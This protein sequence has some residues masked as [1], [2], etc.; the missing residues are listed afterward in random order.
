MNE[1]ISRGPQQAV[2][3]D[4]PPG[5]RDNRGRGRREVPIDDLGGN[6]ETALLLKIPDSRVGPETAFLQGER[7]RILSAAMANLTPRIRRA[8]ELRELGELSTK[9]TARTT[10]V[11]VAAVKARVFHGRKKLRRVLKRVH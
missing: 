1:R 5:V 8:I 11:S 7:R 10:G 2:R 4:A 9:E 3:D 6:K